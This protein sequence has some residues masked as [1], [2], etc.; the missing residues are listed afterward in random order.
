MIETLICKSDIHENFDVPDF[1][2]IQLF[3]NY[4]Q[5]LMPSIAH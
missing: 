5:N 1:E 3:A 4:V 2:A